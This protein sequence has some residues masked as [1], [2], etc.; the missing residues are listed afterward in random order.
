MMREFG[1][2]SFI[3][4]PFKAAALLGANLGANFKEL[5]NSTPTEQRTSNGLFVSAL[6]NYNSD[7]R[8]FEILPQDLTRESMDLF[9]TGAINAKPIKFVA[10]NGYAVDLFALSDLKDAPNN[11]SGELTDPYN[12]ST[13]YFNNL[14]EFI[15]AYQ[16]L[17]KE[18]K[19][20]LEERAKM[21]LLLSSPGNPKNIESIYKATAPDPK[22]DP[23]AYQAHIEEMQ[24]AVK[25]AVR[26]H[27]SYMSLDELNDYAKRYGGLGTLV[28]DREFLIKKLGLSHLEA[29]SL[30]GHELEKLLEETNLRYANLDTKSLATKIDKLNDKEYQRLVKEIDKLETKLLKVSPRTDLGLVD[31][32]KIEQKDKDQVRNILDWFESLEIA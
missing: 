5:L 4:A 8:F 29:Q 23:E 9:V 19:R 11:I 24:A 13:I 26:A 6:A 10:D 3:T 18:R 31:I 27:R 12:G 16:K 14:N 25:D 21:D 2:L 22:E 32:S 1:A 7:S 28:D 17:E 15:E 30:S 20:M